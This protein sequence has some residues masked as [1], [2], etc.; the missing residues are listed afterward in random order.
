MKQEITK[1]F[2][3]EAAHFLPDVPKGHKC[4]RMHGHSFRVTIGVRGDVRDGSGWVLD[5]ADISQA[6]RP[7]ADALDHRLLNEVPGLGNPTSE[8][9][10]AW[11]FDRLKLPGLYFV[12][13]AETCSSSCRLYACDRDG[14]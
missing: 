10:A 9:V 11:I 6:W 14:R 12:E 5:F 4:G 2:T 3:F 13:V 7:L 1:S 8:V